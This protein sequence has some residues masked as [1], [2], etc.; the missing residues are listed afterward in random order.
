VISELISVFWVVK[1][2]KKGGVLGGS[3][4]QPPLQLLRAARKLNSDCA[5]REEELEGGKCGWRAAIALRHMLILIESW[6]VLGGVRPPP[7]IPR[8]QMFDKEGRVV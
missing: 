6:R 4:T 5:L 1:K 3:L 8:F 7:L 2:Q